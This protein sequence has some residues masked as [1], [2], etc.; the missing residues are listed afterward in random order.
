MVRKSNDKGRNKCS[1]TN[2]VEFN[3]IGHNAE[4]DNNYVK[5]EKK[6]TTRNTLI[7]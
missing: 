4:C 6:K 3:L 1:K 5:I 7:L 2:R